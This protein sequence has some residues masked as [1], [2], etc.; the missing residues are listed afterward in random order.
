MTYM[1]CC[2]RLLLGIWLLVAAASAAGLLLA[3]DA[4]GSHSQPLH[5]VVMADAQVAESRTINVDADTVTG[6]I[7]S[8]QGLNAGPR[9]PFPSM[10]DLTSQYSAIGVDYV[11]T[12]DYFGPCDMNE[13]FPDWD[14][15]PTLESSYD[16]ASSDQ[17]LNA[18]QAAGAEVLFRIGYSWGDPT[19]PITY[20]AYEDQA[21][22]AEIARHVVMHYNDGWANGFYYDI[23]YWEVWNEPDISIFWTG[24]PDEYFQLY[25]ATAQAL[26]THDPTLRVG[27]PA[28]CCNWEF[29]AAFLAYA[30]ANGVPVD[31][32][33]WHTYT[34]DPYDPYEQAE[35]AQY[36]RNL[37]G[38]PDAE[39]VLDEWNY[40]PGAVNENWNAKGAAYT[41][42]FLAY[43]QDTPIV[44][45]NR[46]RGNGG[47]IASTGMGLFN[48]D[49]TYKK[50]AYT[51]LAHRWLLDTPLRLAATGSD[52]LGYT[53]LAGKSADEERIVVVVS[54]LQSSYTGY[55]LTIDNLPWGNHPFFYE[56]YLLDAA[57]DLELAESESRS[58]TSVFSTTEAMS[59]ESVQ[60][61][62]LTRSTS[63]GGIAELPASPGSSGP[64][65]IALAGLVAV[66][67]VA[68][69]AGA[70]YARRRWSG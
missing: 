58:G 29:L 41:A 14:A 52:A 23:R 66:T 51:Y 10:A 11:R 44:I 9:P 12:H 6:Q 63:V 34:P 54:D 32:I 30:Q 64:N 27:G 24:T 31:F 69:A 53:V 60:V 67:L 28:L 25:E 42:S 1:T 68:L 19:A 48:D 43:M 55:A 39:L 20:V 61:V 18:I 50:P 57:H 13:I 5:T 22:W 36:L 49:G 7:R 8:L 70:W 56:R 38:F 15:D 17:E 16:F 4:S 46:Y 33:S 62:K 26:K 37:F 3:R 59:P 2:C 45:S 47:G 21:K 65:H 40:Y 35:A